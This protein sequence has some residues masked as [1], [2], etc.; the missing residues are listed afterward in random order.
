EYEQQ[1]RENL[2]LHRSQDGG[3]HERALVEQLAQ[4]LAD[5]EEAASH[6]QAGMWTEGEPGAEGAGEGPKAPAAPA[7]GD[8]SLKAL[9]Y[10]LQTNTAD[11]RDGIYDELADRLN[12]TRRH[13]QVSLWIVV[14]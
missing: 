5:V 3:E 2:A 7:P 10:W 8:R 14:P 6:P 12:E 1:L 13:Y 9:V 4:N 11:L